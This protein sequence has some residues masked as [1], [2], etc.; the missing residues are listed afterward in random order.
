MCIECVVKVLMEG[1]SLVEYGIEIVEEIWGVF[2]E[3]NNV[4]FGIVFVIVE[5][6]LVVE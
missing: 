1:L 4:V 2:K 6:L 5:M 3:I